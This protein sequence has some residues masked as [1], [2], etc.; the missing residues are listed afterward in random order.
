[1]S[2]SWKIQWPK[3]G[4]F[5]VIYVHE[6]VGDVKTALSHVLCSIWEWEIHVLSISPFHLIISI[7]SLHQVELYLCCMNFL[8]TCLLIHE[9]SGVCHVLVLYTQFCENMPPYSQKIDKI[10]MQ[11]IN[12]LL[13]MIIEITF[14]HVHFWKHAYIQR[15]RVNR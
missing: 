6:C 7:R 1:M 11:M 9:K 14:L 5:K 8:K 12:M 13:K 2:R 3:Q 15:R 4:C 10:L